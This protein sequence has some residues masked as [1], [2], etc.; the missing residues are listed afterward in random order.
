MTDM[1]KEN[2]NKIIIIT[3]FL[4]G[5]FCSAQVGIN[6]TAPVT[7][8]MLDISANSSTNS[9]GV[10]FPKVYLLSATDNTTISSPAKGL[11]IFN[12]N[13]LMGEGTY[14][15]KGT[16]SSPS[17]Q[18]MKLLQSNTLSRFIYTMVYSGSITNPTQILET[19]IFQ[20]RLVQNGTN[21]E[22]QMRLKEIPSTNIVTTAAS[23]LSWNPTTR[24]STPS[25]SLAWNISNW[26]VWQTFVTYS[27][28]NEGL[29]YFGIQG[30]DNLFRISLSVA[31]SFNSLMV[32]KF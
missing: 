11:I 3:G 21:C 2:I 25:P 31:N 6:T 19:D 23:A 4:A 8:S 13:S 7:S 27:T 1:N 32:E 12:I 17:W 14:V 9:K 22:I 5:S 24:S 30:T 10:L 18:K 15:N 16:A 26:N 28:N 20:W 29:T